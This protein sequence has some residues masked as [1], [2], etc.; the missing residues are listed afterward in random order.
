MTIDR[1]LFYSATILSTFFLHSLAIPKEYKCKCNNF[2]QVT[3]IGHK[4]IAPSKK[5]FN[6]YFY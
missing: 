6:N 4:T 2:E 1:I 5:C 3:S